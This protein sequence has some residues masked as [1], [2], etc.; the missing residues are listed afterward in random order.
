MREKYQEQDDSLKENLDQ[1]FIP[2]FNHKCMNQLYME[3]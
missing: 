2:I 3:L 1:Q